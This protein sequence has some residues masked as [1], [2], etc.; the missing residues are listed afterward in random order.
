MS[1]PSLAD[2]DSATLGAKMPEIT[3]ADGTVVQTG[4]VGALLM[5]IKAC[6]KAHAAG[7]GEK[8]AKLQEA[9]CASLPLLQV[10]IFDLFT[11]EEW[12]QGSNEGRKLVG[13]LALESS[14]VVAGLL[15]V[16]FCV[17]SHKFLRHE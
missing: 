14:D 5:N 10:G 4:T 6:S 12:A 13:K 8:M 16:C 11:P 9:T 3:L 15:G 17:N 1:N 7:D 2:L